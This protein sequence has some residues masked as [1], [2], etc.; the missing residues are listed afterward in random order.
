[1]R[2]SFASNVIP[3][4]N[5]KQDSIKIN[6]KDIVLKPFTFSF[7]EESSYVTTVAKIADPLRRTKL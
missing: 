2:Y 6:A 3:K 4:V 7:E 5:K 1:V